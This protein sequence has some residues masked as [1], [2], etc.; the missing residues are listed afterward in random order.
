MREELLL[1]RFRVLGELGRSNYSQVYKA[2][3]TKME[4]IVAI[5]QIPASPKTLPRALREARTTA[6]LN[7]PNITTLYE[8]LETP[9]YYY[10][11]MEYVGGVPLADILKIKGC[12]DEDESVAVAIQVC[13]ALECAHANNII[14]RDIKPENLILLA[15]GRIKVMD[16]GISKLI[17][18]PA[19]NKEPFV[20]GTVAYMPPEQAQGESVDERSDIFSLGVVLY[21]MLTGESPFEAET[22]SAAIF[23]ILNTHPVPPSN[24]NPKIS[25]RLDEIVMKTLSKDPD[26]R[27]ESVTEMRY[28][29][30]RCLSTK[31]TP[32]KILKNIA[33]QPSL[34]GVS[35]EGEVVYEKHE[36][37]SFKTNL[38]HFYEDHKGAIQRLLGAF[39][40]G[41]LCWSIYKAALSGVYPPSLLMVIPFAIFI[42][43]LLSPLIGVS[44][45]LATLILPALTYSPGF[46][47]FVSAFLVI[48]WLSLTRQK[49]FLSLIPFLA[50]LLAS[51]KLGLLFPLLAGLTLSPFLAGLISGLG[52]VAI[53]ISTIYTGYP[54]L[55]YLEMEKGVHLLINLAEEFD[56]RLVVSKTIEPF[57]ENPTLLYQ[58][59]IWIAVAV[60]VSVFARK[61]YLFSDILSVLLGVMLL[62]GG[63]WFIPLTIESSLLSFNDLMAELAFPIIIIFGIIALI[64]HKQLRKE[65]GAKVES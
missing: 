7:H 15:D 62:V 60:L 10:L 27:F 55:K 50:P 44:L 39:M 64:P 32:Q 29:L 48:Y 49:P 36:K 56:L 59:A 30:E 47:L 38:Y 35:A 14:H 9:D 16:F 25:K 33:S 12:L 17:A 63:Y 51:L 46:G 8:F 2:L 19:Q 53:I 11:I 42:I 1:E 43:S 34:K 6:L 21:E 18:P 52:C 37:S 57:Y 5:K 31:T 20:E 61:K 23:K 13:Q 28:K 41:G 40:T 45:F 22:A 24:L 26:E 4:R 65:E 3:D 54:S 58:V